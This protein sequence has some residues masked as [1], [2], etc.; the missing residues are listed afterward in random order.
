MKSSGKYVIDNDINVVCVRASSFPE[1]IGDAY[2]KLRSI[3]PSLEQRTLYGISYGDKNGGTIYR[4]AATELHEGEAQEL[5]LE[6]FIIRKGEYISELLEDWR[7]DETKIGKTFN[8]LLS[9]PRID[10][11]QGYCLEIYFNEKDVRCLVL[12]D[13]PANEH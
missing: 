7:K 1:G 10:K 8:Q 13:S 12:L 4:A 6:K 3:L 11:K 5:G 9:D 2:Q